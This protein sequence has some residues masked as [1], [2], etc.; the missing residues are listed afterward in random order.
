MYRNNLRQY[1]HSERI[2]LQIV[3]YPILQTLF[4]LLRLLKNNFD[5]NLKAN[6]QYLL[7]N[8]KYWHFLKF[9]L[10]DYLFDKHS[11]QHFLYSQHRP[12]VQ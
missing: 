10:L 12:F 8:E 9:R 6:C 3:L 4:R 2:C 1:D 11:R 5:L 7:H